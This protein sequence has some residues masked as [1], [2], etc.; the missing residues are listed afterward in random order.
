MGTTAKSRRRT[1]ALAFIVC[2]LFSAVAAADAPQDEGQSISVDERAEAA[3]AYDRGT[4]AYLSEQYELAAHWFERA[5]RLVAASTALVQA[6]RAHHKAGNSIRA[7][8]LALQLQDE[9]P[10]DARSKQVTSAVVGAIKPEN[11]LV[12]AR[13]EKRCTLEIDG[14]EFNLPVVQNYKHLGTQTL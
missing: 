10:G 5:Y 3:E 1:S 8:N 11:V 6:V 7:A 12:E 9:Y 2:M 4:T 13:C 14:D